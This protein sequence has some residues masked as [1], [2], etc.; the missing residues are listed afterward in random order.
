MRSNNN[1]SLGEIEVV[2]RDLLKCWSFFSFLLILDE[3][4]WFFFFF[5]ILNSLSL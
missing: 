1:K 5:K 3:L 2:I 4:C